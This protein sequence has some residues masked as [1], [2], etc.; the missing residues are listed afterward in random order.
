VVVPTLSGAPWSG[1]EG[2]LVEV[3]VHLGE[4]DRR[5]GYDNHLD[6][7][8]VLTGTHRGTARIRGWGPTPEEADLAGW[9]DAFA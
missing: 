5:P 3:E 6:P 1:H 7:G 9:Q 2:W 4:A 8:D